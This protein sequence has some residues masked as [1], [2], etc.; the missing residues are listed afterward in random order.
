MFYDK[1]PDKYQFL[2]IVIKVVLLD[3]LTIA[4]LFLI[5]L[6]PKFN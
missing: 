4:R 3:N 5:C 2:I 1:F 6:N